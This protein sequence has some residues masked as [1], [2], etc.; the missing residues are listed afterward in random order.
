MS[1]PYDEYADR[2]TR[3]VGQ[4]EGVWRELGGYS[5]TE[6]ALRSLLADAWLSGLGYSLNLIEGKKEKR[7]LLSYRIHDAPKVFTGGKM[8]EPFHYG[9]DDVQPI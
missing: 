8:I 6:F 5:I 2:V 1:A 3:E 7:G 9:A 4:N